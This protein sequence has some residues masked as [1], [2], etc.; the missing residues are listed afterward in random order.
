[1]LSTGEEWT[2]LEVLAIAGEDHRIRI[3]DDRWRVFF[4]R[5]ASW[6]AELET[7]VFAFPGG[8]HDDQVDSIVQALDYQ[9]PAQCKTTVSF[10]NPDGSVHRYRP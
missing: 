10:I 2:V 1:M 6:L 5:R 4:P 8:R 3:A 7:E 9:P